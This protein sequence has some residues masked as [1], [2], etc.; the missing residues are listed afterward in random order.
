MPAFFPTLQPEELLYSAIARYGDMLAY[1]GVLP[2][3]RSVYGPGTAARPEVEMCG[4]LSAFLD[5]LPPGHSLTPEE[6]LN[7][8]TLVPYYAFSRSEEDSDRVKRQLSG[9][10]FGRSTPQVDVWSVKP[11]DF[12]QFCPRCVERDLQ[13]PLSSPY[14]RR[15][16][17]L[18]GVVVCPEHRVPLFTS[19]VGRHKDAEPRAFVSLATVFDS[20]NYSEISI[21]DE[22]RQRCLKIAED[23]FWILKDSCVNDR[24]LRERHKLWCLGLGWVHKN[25][26]KSGTINHSRLHKR[27][28]KT[29]DERLLRLL[30]N[31]DES[32]SVTGD[33]TWLKRLYWKKYRRTFH[34][35]QHILGWQLIGLSAPRFFESAPAP[36]VKPGVKAVRCLKGPC[37]NTFCPDFDPPVPRAHLERGDPSEPLIVSCPTC[38]FTYSQKAGCT[39]KQHRR[40]KKT[41]QLWDD[42]LRE[43]LLADVAVWGIWK[44][45]GTSTSFIMKRALELGLWKPEWSDSSLHIASVQSRDDAQQ[46][47]AIERNRS[48]WLELQKQHPTAGRTQLMKHGVSAYRYLRKYDTAWY[49]ENSPAPRA[50]FGN[51]HPEEWV[52][53]DVEIKKNVQ[54]VIEEIL[55][56]AP[57]VQVQLTEISR[58]IGGPDLAG[59]LKHLPETKMII[60]AAIETGE[61]YIARKSERSL[62]QYL[63]EGV[64][65]SLSNFF[66]SSHLDQ[67]S[68]YASVC[69]KAYNTLRDSLMDGTQV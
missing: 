10:K 39:T 9:H 7:R 46:K 64:L 30:S 54:I 29:Y 18:A 59:R 21:P 20:G 38:E 57:P 41:G 45:L 65:P 68:Q 14:W 66:I 2:L 51:P 42:K 50:V 1:P 5:R 69:K 53:V 32:L 26:A 31:G 67:R 33:E 12:L 27:Y 56:E 15:V 47:K 4:P 17:Q 24:N 52:E 13:G 16:H 60:D 58:R 37:E 35:L 19:K 55:E 49:E 25:T 22:Y 34:P 6:L 23:T 28:R 48:K 11:P 36:V 63:E 62:R 44:Q 43:L 8:H 61:Q 40:I 3:W